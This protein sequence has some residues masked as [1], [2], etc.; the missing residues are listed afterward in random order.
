MYE[1]PLSTAPVIGIAGTAKNTGKTTALNALLREADPHHARVAVTSIGYDGESIDTVTF[2]SKP[3]V[4]LPSGSIA[5]T[6]TAC[7]PVHGWDLLETTG[8]HTAL[9]DVVIVQCIDPGPIVLAGPNKR[10]EL[11]EVV[12]GMRLYEPE[13]ILIDGAL[14]RIAPLSVADGIVVATGAARSTRLDELGAEAGAIEHVLGLGGTP[15]PDLHGVVECPMVPTP[16]DLGRMLA[17][18]TGGAHLRFPG[19]APT[20]IL[21]ACVEACRSRVGQIS[22]MSFDS[23]FPLLLTGDIVRAGTMVQELVQMGVAIHIRHKTHLCAVTVNPFYPNY[24][25][26]TYIAAEADADALAAA[27][28]S[29]VTVPIVDIMRDG[30]ADLWNWIH[31]APQ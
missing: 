11:A 30:A 20:G 2:L 29:R 4:F 6:S 14:N 8:F 3:R 9:G 21:R 15:F 28:R 22:T 19:M 5:T 23:A 31:L 25:G 7:V 17:G 26:N 27:V 18:T 1:E 24:S 12:R 10:S 16:E 13:L